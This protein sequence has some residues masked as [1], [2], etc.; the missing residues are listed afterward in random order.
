MHFALLECCLSQTIAV[1][2][3]ACLFNTRANHLP[4]FRSLVFSAL[5]QTTYS[6][7]IRLSFQHSRKPFTVLSFAC[8]FSTHANHLSCIYIYIHICLLLFSL[9]LFSL[10]LLLLLL[11]YRYMYSALMLSISWL[12]RGRQASRVSQK[13]NLIVLYCITLYINDYS[14]IV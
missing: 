4:S 5:A 3:F 11:L 9:L 1:P 12:P 7:F 13:V 2:S 6:P 14:L 8:L 10:L